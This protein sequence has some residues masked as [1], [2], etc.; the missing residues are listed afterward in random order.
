MDSIRWCFFTPSSRFLSQFS[1]LCGSS[2]GPTG[3]ELLSLLSS[4]LMATAQQCVCV[5]VCARMCLLV[6]SPTWKKRKCLRRLWK[7]KQFCL[8]GA[9]LLEII[10][11]TLMQSS[12]QNCVSYGCVC[13]HVKIYS[14]VLHNNSIIFILFSE[15]SIFF[16]KSY[17]TLHLKKVCISNKK[18][19]LTLF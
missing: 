9:I 14:S 17:Y 13:V 18:I 11:S 10:Y 5:Y 16:F 15:K 2:C 12:A 19:F 8:S 3:H 7:P 4:F 6:C 1:P